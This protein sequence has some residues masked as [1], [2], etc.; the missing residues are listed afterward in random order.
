MYVLPLGGG[1][2]FLYQGLLKKGTQK[3]NFIGVI[4]F[5]S[6]KKLFFDS[7]QNMFNAFHTISVSNLVCFGVMCI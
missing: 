6:L 5:A 4:V 3:S 2:R 7:H 1:S